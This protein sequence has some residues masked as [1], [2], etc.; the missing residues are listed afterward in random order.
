MSDYKT[1]K[2][3][4]VEAVASDPANPGVGQVW[5]YST[6]GTMKAYGYLLGAGSWSAGGSL[7]TQRR[8]GSVAGTQ[9]A[10]ITTGGGPNITACELYNGTSWTASPA[11]INYG[12]HTSAGFGIQT[13]AMTVGGPGQVLSETWDGTSWAE[14]NNINTPGN[15]GL[16]SG[17]TTAGLTAFAENSPPIGLNSETYDGTSWSEGNN[18]LTKRYGG[19]QSSGVN[20]NAM[21]SSGYNTPGG[22]GTLVESWNGT[23][24]VEENNVNTGRYH[25]NGAGTGSSMIMFG[26]T[27]APGV[28]ALVEQWNGTSWT[29]VADL[30]T[31]RFGPGGAGTTLAAVCTAGATPV[32]SLATEEWNAPAGNTTQTFTSS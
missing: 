25:A 18:V 27:P 12:Y 28:G 1:I 5:Y 7:A 22:V 30:T 2:G 6:S 16:G 21:M 8:Y 17:T 29:E 20:T 15:F 23:S 32:S 31:A 10:T 26:G 3:W 24:W 19:G 9:T 14:G 11:S 13:A 4:T